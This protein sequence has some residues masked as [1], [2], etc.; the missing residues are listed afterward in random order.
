MPRIQDIGAFNALREAGMTKLLPPT[1]RITVGMGTCGQGNGAEGLYHAFIQA[2]ERTGANVFLTP[3][4][5]FGACSQEPLVS[6]RLPGKP[7]M[8]LRRVQASDAEA[9]LE[10]VQQ[11][12]ISPDLVY[13]KIEE[14]DHITGRV[15]YG[16]GFPEVPS[17]NEVS[18]FKNQKK[19]VLRNC[20]LINPDDIEEYIAIGGYQALYKVLIDGRPEGVIEQIKAAKLRGRGGAGF[21][22]GNKWEFLAKAKSD[23]KYIICNADEGDPGAYMNRNEIESDPHALLEGMIIGGYVMGAT[24]G[25][26]YVRAEYPLAVHRVNRA[27]EQAREY[28]MLGENILGRGFKF[29]IEVVEGA[30]AFVCGEETALIASLENEAGRPRPRPPFPAQKGLWGRPTNINNVE[31]WYNIVPIVMRGP[32]WFTETGGTKSAGTKVFSLVGKVKNTGLVE[33]PLGTPLKTFVYDIGEGAASGR[34]VKAVQTGGPSGGCV[35]AEMFDT[36]VDYENLAQLGSIMGSGGMVVMDEDNCMVD[37]ARYFID[38]TQSESC[39]KCIPCRVG[40]NKCLRILNHIT[41]GGG[42]QH[43]LEL[44]DDLSCYIRDCSLCG[45]GQTAPNPVLTTLRHFRNEFEDH[46]VSRRCSAGVCEELALSPCENSCPLHMNIPRFLQLYEEGRIEDALLS[47]TFDNPLPASTGRVCQHPCDSRCRRQTLD[48]SVNMR[49]IHRFLADSVFESDR[50]EGFVQKVLA[51]RL[52]PTGRKIAVVGAGPAGLTAAFYLA[53][54]GHDVTVYDSKPEA[55][56]MLRFALP[57]YR[58]PKSILRCEIGLI[59]R[60]GVKFIFNTRVGADI[61]LNELDDNYDMIFLSIGTWKESW[62]YQSGTELAGVHTA[63]NFLAAVAAGQQFALGRKVAIIGGGNAAIDSARTASRKGSE[64]TV[65][66]RRDYKDMPAIEEETQAAK[67]EGAKFVFRAAPHRILGDAK[68]NV[69]AIEIVKTRLGEYDASGRRKPVNTDEIKRFDCDSVIFAVGETVDLDFV[70]ASGL[71]LKESGTIDVNRFTLETSRPR[72]YAGGDL[73]TGASNVSNAMAFG[74]QA[75]RNMD[76]Q[77]MEGERWDQLF[78]Q[79]TYGQKPPEEPSASTRHGGH[80]L[81]A[82]IRAH[83]MDEV[84]AGLTDQEALDEA[85]RCLRCDIK[86][87]SVG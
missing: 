28:G 55:G 3:V 43:H 11:G 18:F 1:T 61:S 84:V 73:V 14:W 35:P 51:R 58:L 36:P 56:G 60:L 59:E 9:I 13:S 70:K 83:S 30:G 31:T 34:Q 71:I 80:P 81:A 38:F 10:D 74:K 15:R 4:G 12:G 29:D 63:L 27:I 79:F 54:L 78:P 57:E 45:L 8:M 69:K 44:L 21:L 50:Y 72:F 19:I 5:C 67:E 24:E 48:Q 25:I 46:I 2:I 86:T 32:A 26:I 37:V 87:A 23:T 62:V 42:S 33:M 7:L 76:R 47:V 65:F 16:I 40:L 39:G 41:T 22:T 77:I 52:E 75:A 53:L 68:G 49:E 85:C 82:S 64:V 66:Y 20:G 17:W 6:V